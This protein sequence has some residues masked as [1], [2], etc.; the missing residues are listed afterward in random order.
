MGYFSRQRILSCPVLSQVDIKFSL[1]SMVHSLVQV[2]SKQGVILYVYSNCLFF[3]EG[4]GG[5]YCVKMEKKILA[6]HQC[7]GIF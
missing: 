1:A 4:S 6:K 2:D 3:R 5:D 7:E